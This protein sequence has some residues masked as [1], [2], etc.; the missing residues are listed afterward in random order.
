MQIVQHTLPNGLQV[1]L[2]EIH[3]VPMISHWV[4]YRVGSKEESS[5]ITGISHWVEHL[6]FKGT[7]KNPASSL[8]RLISREG[9]SWNAFT[10]QD[11][12]TYFEVLPAEKIELALNLESDRM[13]NSLF[14][15][16]DVEAERTVIMAERQGEE[17]EP[18]FRL[19]E[20][21]GGAAFRVHPYHH[22]IIGDMA[23][24]QTIQRDDIFRHYRNYYVP[25]NA[26]I[27]I[28]GDFDSQKMLDKVSDIYAWL[29]R[30]EK[31]P[32]L[33][34]PEPTQHGERRVMVHGV[35]ETTFIQVAYHAPQ[36]DHADFIP[37]MVLDSLFSGAS[38]L[39]MFGGGGVSNKTSRL[40][41]AL[42]ESD[43]AVGVY[44]SLQ[45][46]IDPYIYNMSITLRPQEEAAHALQLLED[47]VKRIQ[48]TPPVEE[49]V[50]RAVTQAKALFAYGSESITN[51]AFWLG[52][53]EMF[54]SYSWFE[55][56]LESIAAVSPLDVQRVA[57]RYLHP[58]QRTVGIFIPDSS[59]SA[60]ECEQS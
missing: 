28:A 55:G 56:Y 36:A 18:T 16:E 42:V 53:A 58:H 45:A 31:P 6:Q 40:Y 27:S 52:Y 51:Q 26:V 50:R 30:G 43:V 54:A 15:L 12:T 24:L 23:D 29:P 32:R 38:G 41:R 5:G 2:K 57:Q 21:V 34:R 14:K 22:E 20:E 8:D 10:S 39:N 48:D 49:D 59:L 35:G 9:G 3:T 37:L 17:N 1:N 4:W 25:N 19:G 47:E 46:T 44:G 7:T 11:W 13:I 33:I 60:F